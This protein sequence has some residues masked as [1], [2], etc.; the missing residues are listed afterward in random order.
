[1]TSPGL[2]RESIT[3]LLQELNEELGRRGAKADLFLVGGAA[4]TLVYDATR[5]TRDL[6]AVFLPTDVVRAAASALAERHAL[7]ADWLND[8]VK[9]F[10]PGP[11]PGATRRAAGTRTCGRSRTSCA[12]IC[13]RAP[14]AAIRR[15]DPRTTDRAPST[16]PESSPAKPTPIQKGID[17]Q[18]LRHRR[19]GRLLRGRPEQPQRR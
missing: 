7:A 15:P 2:S 8:A 9:G 1:M 14:E 18:H 4:L 11:D 16:A 6:D 19:R 17:R 12:H 5:S 10:L 3:S 13:R